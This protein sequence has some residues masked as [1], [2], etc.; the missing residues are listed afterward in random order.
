MLMKGTVILF[1]ISTVLSQSIDYPDSLNPSSNQRYSQPGFN[2]LNNPN[3]LSN[4]NQNRLSGQ[5][6]FQNQ[7]QNQNQNQF[8]NQNQNPYQ[9]QNQN[10]LGN[11][12]QVQNPNSPYGVTQNPLISSN[13]TLGGVSN[14]AL[15]ISGPGPVQ[16]RSYVSV[17]L[18]SYSDPGFKVSQNQLCQ[19]PS[20][21]AGDSCINSSPQKQGYHC[22]FN[23][24][25]VVASTS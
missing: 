2:N 23:F 10:R 14:A 22:Y 24:M 16:S 5:N 4:Q 15:N 9:S 7:N 3:Q 21:S 13:N 6:Q 19:C 1:F 18:R 12:N 11:Q 25:V 20:G 8:Q 17:Q